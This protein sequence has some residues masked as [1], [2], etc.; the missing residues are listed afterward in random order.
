MAV[1]LRTGEGAEQELSTASP[2]APS[3][4]EDGAPA[5]FAASSGAAARDSDTT[6]SYR[7]S[8]SPGRTRSSGTGISSAVISTRAEVSLPAASASAPSVLLREERRLRRFPG[9]ASPS[10][11]PPPCGR[12]TDAAGALSG[13][14]ADATDAARSASLS[15]VPRRERRRRFRRSP[16]VPSPLCG[17]AVPASAAASADRGSGAAEREASSASMPRSSRSFRRERRLRLRP[18]PSRGTRASRVSG[19]ARRDATGP[20]RGDAPRLC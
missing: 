10:S 8:A 7:Q 3:S 18:S 13:T 16:P 9:A 6:A 5:L 12:S 14:S 20:G 11:A 1:K 17:A 4:R 15:T 2:R 19:A